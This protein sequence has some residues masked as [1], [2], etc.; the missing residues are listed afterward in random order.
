MPKPQQCVHKQT[1]TAMLEEPLERQSEPEKDTPA[2]HIPDPSVRVDRAHAPYQAERVSRVPQQCVQPRV[3]FP[4]RSTSK[5]LEKGDNNGE[6]VER[7]IPYG[8]LKYTHQKYNL[9]IDTGEGEEILDPVIKIPEESDLYETESL[10]QVV[11]TDR[12]WYKFQPKQ[13]DV[14][15]ILAQIN[16]KILRDT[17]LPLTLKDLKAAY[18][19]SPHFKDVYLYMLQN[20][21]PL[22]NSTAHRLEMN[23]HNYM[24]LDGLLFRITENN[25]GEIDTVL[26][27]P[28]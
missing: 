14:D 25:V 13:G 16:H 8:P 11:D 5:P 4:K 20:R 10:N 17:K 24:I 21:A 27:I 26:C 2:Q 12:K 28:T 23:A 22:N 19:T 18:L 6:S 15:K 7:E 3:L 9:D 1:P